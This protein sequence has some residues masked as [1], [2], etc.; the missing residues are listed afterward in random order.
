MSP[1]D[2]SRKDRK[3]RRGV[4]HRCGWSG[5]VVKVRRNERKRLDTGRMYGRLCSECVDDLLH[6]QSS[7]R[8]TEAT[9]RASL[10]VLRNRDVA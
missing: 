6:H 7:L 1:G 5:T 3:R 4:C 9:G 8:S 2:K 10:K